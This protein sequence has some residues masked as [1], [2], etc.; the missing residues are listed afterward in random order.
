MNHS[1]VNKNLWI[2]M[3]NIF[4]FIE[5]HQLKLKNTQGLVINS[6]FFMMDFFLGAALILLQRL[7][8]DLVEKNIVFFPILERGHWSLLVNEVCSHF[9]VLGKQPIPSVLVIS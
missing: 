2:T 9:I 5:F 6:E 4:I 7:L 3:E 8:Q 1:H